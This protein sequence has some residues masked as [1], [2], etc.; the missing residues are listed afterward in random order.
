MKYKEPKYWKYEKKLEGLLYFSQVLN[1]VLFDYSI[2]TYK[3]NALNAHSITHEALSL[4]RKVRSKHIPDGNLKPV[5]EEL[6]LLIKK[7]LVV[8]SLLNEK[9]AHYSKLI[10]E[11]NNIDDLYYSIYSIHTYLSDKKYLEEVK[12]L[13]TETVKE[14]KRKRDIFFLTRVFVT[15]LM[16]YGYSKSYLY[17]LTNQFFF[18]EKDKE[19]DNVD[20][21]SKFLNLFDFKEQ[22]FDVFIQAPAIFWD[23]RK[24]LKEV[25]VKMSKTIKHTDKNVI[26]K[27]FSKQ[28][29]ST[30]IYLIIK[31][32]EALDHFSARRK[33]QNKLNFFINLFHL[34]H[35]R[36]SLEFRNLCCVNRLDNNYTLILDEPINS[37]KKQKDFK[38]TDAA[39]MVE[40]LIKNLSFA[41]KNN[42]IGRFIKA[43]ELHKLALSANEEENQLLDLWAAIETI[44]QKKAESNESR[45]EQISNSL[46]PFL[47]YGYV[48]G[49]LLELFKDLSN[50]D[51]EKFY[52]LLDSINNDSSLR[53]NTFLELLVLEE[54]DSKVDDLLG[55]LDLF[56]LLK[57]R[58]T[59]YNEWF[60][61]PKEVKSFIE[62]HSKKI[63]WQIRRIYRARNTLVHHGNKPQQL[64]I[65]LENLSSYFHKVMDELEELMEHNKVRSIE[66]GIL[67]MKIHYEEN[68]NFINE[69]KS[70]T[71][72]NLNGIFLL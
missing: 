12:R 61:N 68:L 32:V 6:L 24:S 48:K 36:E 26:L 11:A 17:N 2:D 38:S 70:I 29:K 60:K 31:D 42:S 23:F 55:Y 34:Y 69:Q 64:P 51:K 66:H 15:E 30:D 22:K 39:L 33:G 21:I 43:L 65:L 18:Q 3:P 72:E 59:L 9:L 52:E 35:H 71:K 44:F 14:G 45:I 53:L 47:S 62:R 27:S 63:T 13:L 5:R 40:K 41:R 1:E 37:V 50:W 56:P 19:I 25:D 20:V 54:N 4:L 49:L 28:K 7:D 46:I 57:N 58:V 10:K 16:N 8:K 67:E